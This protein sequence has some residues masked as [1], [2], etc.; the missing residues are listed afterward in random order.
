MLFLIKSRA[1]KNMESPGD[2]P[3]PVAK[4]IGS[5]NIEALLETFLETGL[6]MSLSLAQF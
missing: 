2:Y 4:E 1:L 5:W 3:I 6:P